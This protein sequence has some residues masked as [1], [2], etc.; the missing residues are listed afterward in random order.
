[1]ARYEKETGRAQMIGM[2]ADDSK[3]REKVYLQTG[4][5]AYD[6]KH[7]R[8]M[9]LGFWTEQDVIQY[10]RDYRIPYA[11]VYGDIH[12]DPGTGRLYFDGVHS[13]GCI[14]CAFGLHMEDKPNRFQRLRITHPKR[15]RFCM[16][17]LGL[18]QVL[19]Y[20][21]ENCPDRKVASRF[22]YGKF[23]KEEQLELFA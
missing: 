16:E 20:I 11:K 23:V 13:T 1:M 5:N 8:S 3:A 17:K 15:Y 4:C 21:R 6:A 7:P 22:E 10:L 2:M 9:P 18:A 12:Q 14:F 19:D